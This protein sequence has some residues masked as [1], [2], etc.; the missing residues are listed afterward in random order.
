M[1]SS[2]GVVAARWCRPSRM[3]ARNAP[4]GKGASVVMS[5]TE[6]AVCT[7]DWMAANRFCPGGVGP[8]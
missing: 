5:T 3:A 8:V 6:L 7:T 2:N 1:R 4:S